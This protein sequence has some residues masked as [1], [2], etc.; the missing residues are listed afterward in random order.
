MENTQQWKGR[1]IL[2]AQTVIV[3]MDPMEN[4]ATKNRSNGRIE[5]KFFLKSQKE[6]ATPSESFQKIFKFILNFQPEKGK[7][8]LLALKNSNSTQSNAAS[9]T[10]K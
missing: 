8:L 10:P 4:I 1:G 9:R 6:S 2:L 7:I 3:L 5:V